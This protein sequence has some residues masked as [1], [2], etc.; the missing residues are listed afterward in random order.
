[1]PLDIK[2]LLPIIESKP[3]WRIN[4]C[5]AQYRKRIDVPGKAFD[6]IRKTSINWEH[7][8]YPH[9]SNQPDNQIRESEYVASGY[10][11]V[12]IDCW[13]LYFSGQFLHLFQVVE[14]ADASTKEKMKQWA[15]NQWSGDPNAIPGFIH[16][17]ELLHICAKVLEFAARLTEAGLYNDKTTISIQLNKV[18]GFVLIEIPGLNLRD[19][20][21]ATSDKINWEWSGN[22]QEILA[23]TDELALKAACYLLE[24]FRWDNLPVDA[25]RN[26]Q[27]KILSVRR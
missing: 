16:I 14:N 23:K 22:P 12:M 15:L 25:F 7:R 10:S 3:H 2:A 13:L 17:T 11:S 18:K 20:Y 4:F 6:L 5:P 1:M 24:Q 21:L 19:D 27:A 9:L 8:Y 26:L